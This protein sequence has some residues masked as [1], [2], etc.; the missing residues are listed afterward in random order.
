MQM[1]S[2]G[3]VRLIAAFHRH[4]RR[5]LRCPEAALADRT[6]RACS[7]YSTNP[8]KMTAIVD[9]IKSVIGMGDKAAS[10]DLTEEENLEG[11]VLQAAKDKYGL[12]EDKLKPHQK[13]SCIDI[14]SG[15]DVSIIQPPGGGKSMC[16]V[17][18]TLVSS[19]RALVVEPVPP[20]MFDQK[21]SLEEKGLHVAVI[22]NTYTDAE[23]KNKDVDV[24][25]LIKK[26][27]ITYCTPDSIFDEKG[28][29]TKVLDALIALNE[30][31]K[32]A[33]IALDEAHLCWHGMRPQFK[34]LTTLKDLFP[35]VPLM[36]ATGTATKKNRERLLKEFLRADRSVEYWSSVDSPHIQTRC[37][38]VEVQ[39][40]A[41]KHKKLTDHPEETK[42]TPEDWKGLVKLVAEEA[43]NESAL[44][45][46]DNQ[47]AVDVI[48][49]AFRK[50]ASKIKVLTYTG[51][52][53]TKKQ[54]EILKK[55]QD[56]EASLI[57]AT[58]AF[59]HGVSRNDVRHVYHLG[60][61]QSL[62]EWVQ[63]AGRAGRD[64]KP[65][66][67]TLLWHD[68]TPEGM[69]FEGLS[70]EDR[71]E[72]ISRVKAVLSYS[73]SRECRRGVLLKYFGE[74]MEKNTCDNCDICLKLPAHEKI[75]I[76]PH[77]A[78]AKLDL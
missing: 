6:V 19:R 2:A 48:A 8:V 10:K 32:F 69:A 70:K 22:D 31:E 68:L 65:A 13:G 18:P 67:A 52:Y 23:G 14:L 26:V 29:R 46:Y 4:F 39:S 62:E 66:T 76:H 42:T 34:A 43:G 25:A 47:E 61:P 36:A 73:T 57:V 9:T 54:A 40:G 27:D 78:D 12:D 50:Y 71:E 41:S 33:L 51:E 11:K 15:K 24:A 77:K 56:N 59:G 75:V 7:F 74:E 45:F 5:I 64:N 49:E 17:L 55:W 30:A 3:R 63:E 38:Y 20:L 44:L 37:R 53:D 60:V 21:D 72:A 1:L 58:S 16:F 28:N 35:N